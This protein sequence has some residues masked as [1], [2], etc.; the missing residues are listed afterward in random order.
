MRTIQTA[1][2]FNAIY[3]RRAIRRYT[4]TPLKTAELAELIDAAVQ[5]PSAMND[6]PWAFVVLHGT[7]R[8]HGFSDRIKQ[9]LLAQP[10]AASPE[11]QQILTAH[12][13]LFYGS[14]AL[15]VICATSDSRQAAEDCAMAAQNFMLAAFASGLGTCPIGLARAWFNLPEVK[16]ELGIPP[17]FVAVVPLIVGHADEHPDAPGRRA[18]TIIA[19]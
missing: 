15:V 12:E 7:D 9:F 1:E 6:Q 4:A 2:V 14:P 3:Q 11:L 19:P 10:A 18:A 13:N 16:A 5:A 8:L 17:E